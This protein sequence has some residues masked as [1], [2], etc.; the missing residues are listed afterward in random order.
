MIQK[1]VRYVLKLQIFAVFNP[2]E[3][4]YGDGQQIN[5]PEKV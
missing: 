3:V 2:A 1:E 4:M 5:S